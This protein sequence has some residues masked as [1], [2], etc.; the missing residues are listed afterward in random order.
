MANAGNNSMAKSSPFDSEYIRCLKLIQ[1]IEKVS[2][3]L[4]QYHASSELSNSIED[5]GILTYSIEH[6]LKAFK[7][8]EEK[9]CGSFLN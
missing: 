6:A 7:E 2:R 3:F 1:E 9:A 4:K 5:L 8:Q